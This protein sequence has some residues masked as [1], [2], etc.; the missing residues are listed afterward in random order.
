MSESAEHYYYEIALT[1]RQVLV[2]F[3]VLL[4]CILTAF[5]MGVWVGR[6]DQGQVLAAEMPASVEPVE[7]SETPAFDSLEELRFGTD[8]QNEGLD[9]P[10]LSELRGPARQ[11][12]GT[13]P[14]AASA[15]GGGAD[16]DR[17]TTL[18]EDIAR[19]AP[20]QAAPEQAAP[21]QPVPAGAPTGLQ[22]TSDPPQQ[23]AARPQAAPPP[24]PSAA[25]TTPAAA[26]Q[27]GF[28]VQ[29]FSSYD[30]SQA[31]KVLQRLQQ[32]GYRTS[33]LSPVQ[34]VNR[35]MYRVR[36]GPF[37]ERSSAEK[38][39]ESIAADFKLE[40]WITAASN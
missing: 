27:E 13:P 3:V 6:M 29:V 31:R 32:G 20:E 8:P 2:S 1:N 16:P 18:A 5:A 4:C 40:T 14:G 19:T 30:E 28:I 34:V 33:F 7:P 37:A 38:Q 36:V 10:D 25:A 9:K 26:P 23:R 24:T 17:G 22:R 39:A 11:G 12:P 15:G 21:D 35:T